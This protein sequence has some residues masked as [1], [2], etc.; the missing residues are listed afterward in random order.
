[1]V[2]ARDRPRTG[3]PELRLPALPISRS[4]WVRRERW[5]ASSS[6][7]RATGGGGRR[8]G[9]LAR[10]GPL[11]LLPHFAPRLLMDVQR[12]EVV[13]RGSQLALVLGRLQDGQGRA[14]PESPVLHCR[15]CATSVLRPVSFRRL[16]S[17]KRMAASLIR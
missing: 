5:P 2:S 8:D 1:M 14:A 4:T 16:P 9:S 3:L 6:R 15:A 7:N 12:G 17:L 11:Q 13:E 10:D